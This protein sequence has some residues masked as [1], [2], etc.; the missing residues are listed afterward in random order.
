MVRN[1]AKKM[2]LSLENNFS[3]VAATLRVTR[4][5]CATVISSLMKG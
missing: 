1:T 5:L 3:A 4:T 2:Y